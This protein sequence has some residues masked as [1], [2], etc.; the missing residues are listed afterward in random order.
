MSDSIITTSQEDV[1]IPQ[2]LRIDCS[3]TLWKVLTTTGKK[4]EEDTG[5]ISLAAL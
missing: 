4:A 3:T 1:R 5:T 2:V